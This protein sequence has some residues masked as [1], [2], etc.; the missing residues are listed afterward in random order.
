[1]KPK[2]KTIITKVPT[3]PASLLCL[4]IVLGCIGTLVVY[5]VIMIAAIVVVAAVLI[6]V[7]GLISILPAIRAKTLAQ[8]WIAG[9]K[10]VAKDWIAGWTENCRR[11]VAITNSLT[12]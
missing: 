1:M 12:Q 3:S 2:I 7:L 5:G 11:A 9:G 10:T 4:V 8:E 6:R